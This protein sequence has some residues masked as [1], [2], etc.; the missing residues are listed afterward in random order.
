MIVSAQWANAVGSRVRVTYDDNSFL[1]FPVGNSTYAP[2]TE[3]LREMSS[4]RIVVGPYVPVT[5][6]N[7]D[8]PPQAQLPAPPT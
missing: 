4:G 6:P 1:T 2:W 5:G 7:A 3:L 8:Q